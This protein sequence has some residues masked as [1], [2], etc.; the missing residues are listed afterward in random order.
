MRGGPARK[1]VRIGDNATVIG[2]DDNNNYSNHEASRASTPASTGRQRRST[3][4]ENPQYNFTRQ[5]AVANLG[6]D[7]PAALRPQAS[8]A[9]TAAAAAA[10]GKTDGVKRRGRSP[11]KTGADEGGEVELDGDEETP[12]KKGAEGGRKG[13]L[14]NK[15]PNS[16]VVAEPAA[17][18]E[19]EVKAAAPAKKGRGRPKQV[20]NATVDDREPLKK[21]QKG[22]GR[23]PKTKKAD[24]VDGLTD[25]EAL[26]K[27]SLLHESVD[28][29]IQYW[30]MKAEP[31]SRMEKGVDVKF[32]I[33]DLAAK[34]EPEGWDGVRNPVARNNMRAMRVND[35]AFFYHSNCKKPAIVGVMR[36]VEE[37]S[38]DESAFDPDH[39]YYDPKSDRAKPKWELVKVDFVKKFENEIG[40][41]ELRTFASPG[42][43][44]ENMQML[45]QSRLSV[46]SVS[47]AEWR[48]ILEQLGEPI[49]LGQPSKSGGYEGDTDGEVEAQELEDG[50]APASS[51][52][53]PVNRVNGVEDES[54][55][56]DLNADADGHLEM[57]RKQLQYTTVSLGESVEA[58]DLS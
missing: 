38:I 28:P 56:G 26:H 16:A 30:L 9:K 27:S 22:R 13:I 42:G 23:Q 37:H 46:S 52:E 49:G 20:G 21:V 57:A 12:V 10:A 34:T 11:K 4:N 41:K 29:E 40:L 51:F 44:L 19:A 5:K 48:F 53:T 31:D 32:S 36:I 7:A 8:R 15:N 24:E 43:A 45:K 1:K 54:S 14:K 47:P 39:P 25:E 35:L 18:A 2:D 33:D 55:D 6:G 58:G 17:E 3:S 50:K